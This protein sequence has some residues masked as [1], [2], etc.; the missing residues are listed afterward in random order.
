MV[1]TRQ[2]AEIIVTLF[3]KELQGMQKADSAA[4]SDNYFLGM[5]AIHDHLLNAVNQVQLDLS[6]LA[7]E[8]THEH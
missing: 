5:K 8:T 2:D 1:A 7:Q 6:L 3:Q 4:T